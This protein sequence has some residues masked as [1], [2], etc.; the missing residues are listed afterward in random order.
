MIFT[1]LFF[2]PL[3]WPAK[4]TQVYKNNQGVN[5][6]QSQSKKVVDTWSIAKEKKKHAP[7]GR[8][9]VFALLL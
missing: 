1:E 9:F 3:S 2:Y 4:F 8:V 7:F 5:L 6:N